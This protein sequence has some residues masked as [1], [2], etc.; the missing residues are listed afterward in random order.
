MKFR[1]MTSEQIQ[2][3][4]DIKP[5]TYYKVRRLI[6]LH[7]ERYTSYAV[8]DRHTDG[9][10]FMDAKANARKLQKGEPLPEYRCMDAYEALMGLIKA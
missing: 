6:K 7:P 1:F 2:A 10:A 5:C 8:Q 9:C 3:A 4:F